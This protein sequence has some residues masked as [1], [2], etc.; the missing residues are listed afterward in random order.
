MCD[1]KKCDLAFVSYN[2][3]SESL[4]KLKLNF[5]EL[6]LILRSV[7][8]I[9]FRRGKLYMENNEELKFAVNNNL[10]NKKYF[11]FYF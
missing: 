4:S 3:F 6:I 10:V 1:T 2:Q 7:G 11:Q 5:H 8:I 9:H